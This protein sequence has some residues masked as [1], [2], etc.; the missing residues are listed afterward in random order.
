MTSIVE[1]IS[2]SWRD[3]YLLT[4]VG[5]HK[6]IF[7]AQIVS[8]ILTIER[9]Q[10]LTLPFYPQAVLGVVHYLGKIVPLV[11][12][13]SFFPQEQ[14]S[15]YHHNLITIR[16]NGLVGTAVGVGVIVNELVGSI[17]T[18]QIAQERI[19]QPSDLPPN[20]WKPQRWYSDK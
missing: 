20:L 18:E 17:T 9:T 5:S 2:S 10:V 8:D 7:S 13:V 15:L 16:L 4:Q 3:R 14:Q 1:T 6:L 19:F 11:S 12:A